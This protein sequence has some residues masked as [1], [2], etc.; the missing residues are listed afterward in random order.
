MYK[1]VLIAAVLASLAAACAKKEEP[2]VVETPVTQEPVYT[3]KY[4]NAPGP[5]PPGH[6][7]PEG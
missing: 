7:R 1:T 4:G 6:P 5:G 2:V 3:G